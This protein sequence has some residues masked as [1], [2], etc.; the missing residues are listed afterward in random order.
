MFSQG[1]AD[2]VNK[3]AIFPIPLISSTVNTVDLLE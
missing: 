1:L 3:K 2:Q